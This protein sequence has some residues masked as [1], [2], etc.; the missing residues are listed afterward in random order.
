MTS[1]TI[2]G[3]VVTPSVGMMHGDTVSPVEKGS[4]LSP[5]LMKNKVSKPWLMEEQTS[6]IP[7]SDAT[8]L[9]SLTV[10]PTMAPATSKVLVAPVTGTGAQES[11]TGPA[12]ERNASTSTT[13]ATAAGM[14]SVAPTLT[15]LFVVWGCASGNRPSLLTLTNPP[16]TSVRANLATLA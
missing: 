13:Q 8:D 14:I 2:T 1:E 9:V 12:V 6:T 7:E 3:S 15:N 4:R 11:P 10:G 5:I 16:S